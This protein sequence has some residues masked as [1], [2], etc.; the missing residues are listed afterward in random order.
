MIE[1]IR[2]FSIDFNRL[3]HSFEVS[4]PH[5]ELYNELLPL[6]YLEWKQN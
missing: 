6:Y 4:G 2:Y 5:H 3:W 1:L